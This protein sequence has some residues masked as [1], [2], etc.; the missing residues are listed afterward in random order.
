MARTPVL[1]SHTAHLVVLRRYQ[2]AVVADRWLPIQTLKIISIQ[3]KAGISQMNC[4]KTTERNVP[5]ECNTVLS[6]HSRYQSSVVSRQSSVV[7]RQSSVVSRQSSVVSRQSSVVS[8]QSSVVSRQSSVVSCQ[9]RRTGSPVDLHS[10]SNMG[11]TQ[12]NEVRAAAA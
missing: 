8:R 6:A 7:S 10:K 11:V 4:K 5:W 2:T 9:L 12:G 1:Y 3:W